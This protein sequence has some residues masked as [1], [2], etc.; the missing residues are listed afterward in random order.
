MEPNGTIARSATGLLLVK[1]PTNTHD[2]LCVAAWGPWEPNF[3][4]IDA[5]P[6]G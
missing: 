3:K 4:T 2:P 1:E 5:R 6:R